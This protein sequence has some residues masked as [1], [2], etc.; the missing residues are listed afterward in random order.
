[1]ARTA[2]GILLAVFVWIAIGAGIAMVVRALILPAYRQRQQQQGSVGGGAEV[3]IP[4]RL[5]ADSF[6]GYCLLRSP[7]FSSRLA[8]QGIALKVVDDAADYMAR[9]RA[10]QAGDVEMAVFPVNSLIQCGARLGAFPGRIVY[11]LDE[12]VGADA[13]VSWKGGVGSIGALNSPAARFV[14]TPDSPSEFL[15]RVVIASFNL[16]ALSR[17]QWLLPVPGSAAVYQRFRTEP[18]QQPYVYALW[19]PEVSRALADPEAQ[20]LLD[21][22]KLKGYV[23]DVLTVRRQFLQEN[24]ALARTLVEEY[25]RTAYAARERMAAAVERDSKAGAAAVS[26]SEAEAIAKGIRWKNTLENYAHFGL[27]TG[28]GL[29]DLATIV[30]KV[31]D[32]LV[33]TEALSADPLAGASERLEDSRIVRDMK[34][35]GFHPGREVNVLDSTSAERSDEQLRG[36]EAVVALTEAQWAALVTVGEMRVEPILFGRG[37]ARLG[38]QGEQALSALAETLASWPRYY[39]S[40]TGRVRPGADQAAALSLAQA[41]AEAVAASLTVKGVAQQRVRIA[42]EIAQSDMPE[43]Q[44]VVFVVR[45]APY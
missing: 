19:E 37:N 45:Q 18:R 38:V 1:M 22:S 7:E 15:A 34:T 17:D 26:R 10:L 27:A 5:A 25:A 30:R 4:V 20:V 28:G 36:A 12:T 39:L 41:R 32:V 43:A 6:S 3:A 40:V 31:T 29:D 13:I 11:V 35:S 33:R 23:V 9:L 24:Y 21:T 42:A 44:A 14:L 8:R 2:K 16:P